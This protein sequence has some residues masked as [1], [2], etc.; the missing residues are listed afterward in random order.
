MKA[1]RDRLTSGQSSQAGLTLIEVIVAIAI[2]SVVALSS[3]GLT[4][5]GLTAAASQERQQVA[6]TIA[7]GAME[8]VSGWSVAVDTGTGVSS[9]YTGRPKTDVQNAF[10]ANL[11]QPAASQTYPAWDPN[12]ASCVA[13]PPVKTCPA[14]PII[15]PVLQNG[16]NYTVTTLMGTCY[17]LTAPAAGAGND[18]GLAS[19]NPNPSS[20]PATTPAGLT[21]LIRVIVIVK[22]T[23]NS[24][25]AAGGCTYAATTLVDPHAD[26]KWDV[27]V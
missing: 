25:C 7:N 8:T 23:Q 10:N 12:A 19:T 9:L 22:W 17:E 14:L 18:C 1:I 11:T 26:L 5:T 27:H 13:N 6:V 4:S 24:A 3:A 2:V 15:K 20:P 21:A 16:T